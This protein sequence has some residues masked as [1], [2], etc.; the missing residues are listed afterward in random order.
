MGQD[1]GVNTDKAKKRPLVGANSILAVML[2]KGDEHSGPKVHIFLP[3]VSNLTLPFPPVSAPQALE[4][5]SS[6]SRLR[7][8]PS[9]VSPGVAVSHDETPR[10]GSVLIGK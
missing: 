6:K 8:L 1:S 9:R 4:K 3:H 7:Y 5:S 2:Q 10:K